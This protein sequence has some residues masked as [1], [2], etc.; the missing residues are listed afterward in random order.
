[1]AKE[2]QAN[3]SKEEY[4]KRQ[5]EIQDYHAALRLRMEEKRQRQAMQ[6]EVQD[7]FAAFGVPQRSPRS[8]EYTSSSKSSK[9]D[10]LPVSK[11]VKRKLSKFLPKKSEKDKEKKREKAEES[12]KRARG[13]VFYSTY[14][15]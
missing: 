8:S 6:F 4:M 9:H 12:K 13:D 5:V 1:M 11:I 10:S 7:E 3:V 14:V 2:L 15:P